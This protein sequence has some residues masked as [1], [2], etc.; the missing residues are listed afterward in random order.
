V[1]HGSNQETATKKSFLSATSAKAAS[2]RI[3]NPAH[4]SIVK[5]PNVWPRKRR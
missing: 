5:A 4:C 1:V 2:I 3:E